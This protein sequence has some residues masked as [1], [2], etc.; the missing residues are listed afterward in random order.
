MKKILLSILF[1]VVGLC[2]LQ[3]QSVEKILA[4]YY[5]ALGGEE[6]INQFKSSVVSSHTYYPSELL[7]LAVNQNELTSSQTKN[8]YPYFRKVITKSD[9]AEYVRID[10]DQ[11]SYSITKGRYST[12]TK[13]KPREHCSVHSA[14]NLKLLHEKG[15]LSIAADTLIQ[16]QK[17]QAIQTTSQ[18]FLFRKSDGLLFAITD[19]KG[20][21]VS[22]F[23][24][25]RNVQGV[26][27][28]FTQQD[29]L[30]KRASSVTQIDS[31]KFNVDI[32]PE[33]F[34]VDESTLVAMRYGELLRSHIEYLPAESQTLKFDEMIRKHFAQKR[35][36]ICIWS[37]TCEDCKLQFRHYDGLLYAFLL[38]L[39]V[40]IVFINADEAANETQ[41]KDD[42]K[43][44]NLNGYHLLAEPG[45]GLLNDMHRLSYV[46]SAF[47][48]SRYI[49]VDEY[50]SVLSSEIKNPSD[51]AFKAQLRNLL[52]K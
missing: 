52:G 19:R 30:M 1:C 4:R 44:L 42:V 24:D 23:T 20:L 38:E 36:L 31:I 9:D 48:I 2:Q 41:W 37:S 26:L 39:D 3:A 45:S 27:F 51:D 43:N 16:D 18:K 35:V 49:L 7:L 33:D 28:P 47:S 6:K 12:S 25:Y 11:G 50:G 29:F 21:S 5:K 15:A 40:S 17:C 32:K 22:I 34:A 10:N 13:S 46:N 14:L 8:L